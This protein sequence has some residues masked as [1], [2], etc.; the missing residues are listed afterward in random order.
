MS[1][2]R[3]HQKARKSCLVSLSCQAKGL[4]SRESQGAWCSDP[5]G[6]LGLLLAFSLPRRPALNLLRAGTQQVSS[7]MLMVVPHR[8]EDLSPQFAGRPFKGYFEGNKNTRVSQRRDKAKLH[9]FPL[10]G[11]L[12][13]MLVDGIC[14]CVIFV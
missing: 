8:A 3:Y 7:Q 12:S 10:S 13:L 14:T 5:A 6:A 1:H 9:P 4:W 2:V 11:S